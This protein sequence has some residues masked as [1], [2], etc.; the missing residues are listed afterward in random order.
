MSRTC[1]P[2]KLEKRQRTPWS[3]REWGSAKTL[4]LDFWSQNWNRTNFCLKTPTL[5]YFFLE[6]TGNPHGW[7]V[8]NRTDPEAGFLVLCRSC[9]SD[10]RPLVH[11][12]DSGHGTVGEKASVLGSASVQLAG[13]Y[14]PGGNLTPCPF[15]LPQWVETLAFA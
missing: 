1:S 5:W 8:A 12:V 6:A 11:A 4:I 14:V 15:L 13:L 7:Q 10:P 2:Q 3:R 9:L